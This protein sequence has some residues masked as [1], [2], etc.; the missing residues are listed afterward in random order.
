[1]SDLLCAGVAGLYGGEVREYA[2]VAPEA[3]RVDEGVEEFVPLA[4]WLQRGL[5]DAGRSLSLAEL[6]KRLAAIPAWYVKWATQQL[7]LTVNAAGRE[8]R[9]Q[10]MDAGVPTVAMDGWQ[11]RAGAG[12]K[13]RPAV[14]KGGVATIPLPERVDAAKLMLQVRDVS[15]GGEWADV[16]A[17]VGA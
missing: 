5:A 10:V 13:Q 1:L 7:R 8:L 14:I 6:A 15:G 4:V 12:G 11:A 3:V 9:V 16:F 2:A 17:R